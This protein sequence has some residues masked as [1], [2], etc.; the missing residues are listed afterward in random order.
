MHRN[1]ARSSGRVV[2]S[3]KQARSH[4]GGGLFLAKAHLQ[5][6][7]VQEVRA[8][9]R[10]FREGTKS[11]LDGFLPMTLHVQRIGSHAKSLKM[12]W[13]MIGGFN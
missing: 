3:R 4:E 7:A 12:P 11:A 10:H 13:V 8:A 1:P 9:A 5:A 6:H 2:S